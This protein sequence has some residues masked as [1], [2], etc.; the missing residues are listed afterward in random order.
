MGRP[1]ESSCPGRHWP[2]KGRWRD[3]QPSGHGMVCAALDYRPSSGSTLAQSQWLRIHFNRK[4]KKSHFW[5]ALTSIAL[6][7]SVGNFKSIVSHTSLP[8]L[9]H[10]IFIFFF[11]HCKTIERRGKE[12]RDKILVAFRRRPIWVRKQLCK[13]INKKMQRCHAAQYF[14]QLIT[15]AL[16]RQTVSF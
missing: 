12:R 9:G 3:E 6:L 10:T 5:A 15:E 2:K 8:R 14:T 4:V 7:C 16:G 1:L 11:W 13:V